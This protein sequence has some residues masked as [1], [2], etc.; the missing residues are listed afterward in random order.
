MMGFRG[1]GSS[2]VIHAGPWAGAHGCNGDNGVIHPTSR[3][4]RL[5]ASVSGC[6][7]DGD[8]MIYGMAAPF[9]ADATGSG[10]GDLTPERL[11]GPEHAQHDHG[12]LARD[13]NR[14]A[15]EPDPFAQ[16]QPPAP[17]R[18]VGRSAGQDYGRCLVE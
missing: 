4:G 10:G 1:A 16:C 2:N 9:G 14:R 11:A 5:D 15:L 7:P 18:A 17:Q 3:Q 8:V 12:E 13:R 6:K